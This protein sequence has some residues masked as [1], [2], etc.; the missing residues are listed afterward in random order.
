MQE[1]RE[2]RLSRQCCGGKH[3]QG[4]IYGDVRQ[5]LVPRLNYNVYY[6]LWGEL[7][8]YDDDQWHFLPYVQTLAQLL[9]A[10]LRLKPTTS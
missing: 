9:E 1:H 2:A 7:P 3:Q 8:R 5:G 6:L 4:Q 10:G